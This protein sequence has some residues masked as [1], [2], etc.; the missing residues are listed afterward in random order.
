MRA[1]IPSACA[2]AC[3]FFAFKLGLQTFGV[4]QHS[5]HGSIWQ[6]LAQQLQ[7]LRFQV[8]AR[9]EKN[10][11]DIAPRPVEACHE[12]DLDRIV[13]CREH[14]GDRRSRRFGRE[15]CRVSGGYNQGALTAN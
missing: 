3:A 7:L 15:R 13:A 9:V 1:D 6:S 14:D 10:A 11:G 12:I 4:N 5:Y 8:C 2:A